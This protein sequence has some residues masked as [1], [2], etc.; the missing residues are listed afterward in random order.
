MLRRSLARAPLAIGLIAAALAVAGCPSSAAEQEDD[1]PLDG[2]ATYAQ[3][4]ALCH[5]DRGQGYVADEATQLANPEFLATA[6][7][8]FLAHAIER[9]RPGTVMSAWGRGRGGPLSGRDIDVVVEFIRSW[10]TK[11]TVDV[12]GVRVSGDPARA[13]PV[14]DEQCARCHG[15]EGEGG[16]Y[17]DI[18]NPE[19]LGSASDGFLQYAIANGR[20]GTPMPAFADTLP[21][22]TIDDLVALLRSW[23]RMPPSGDVPY[24]GTMGPVVLNPDGPDPGFVE[25]QR[26]TPVDDVYAALE[27]GAAMG[28]LDAR[29]PSD[30]VAGHIAGATSVPFYDVARLRDSLPRDQ[31]LVAYCACPHAESGVVADHLLS[32]GFTKV[33][34]L[35]EGWLAW[36]DRGYP[37][38]TGASP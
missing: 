22:E 18:A 16:Q 32:H 14:Y 29:P 26:F 11:P 5:G 38:K 1:T 27:R 36:R 17:V 30:Y 23:Q 7:D 3:M 35:D 15:A 24:P 9:G 20:P 21:A 31:W 12:S 19:L 10:Q 4:C 34:I 33:T 37:V 8:A 6:T 28:F 2:P 13:K 25:G